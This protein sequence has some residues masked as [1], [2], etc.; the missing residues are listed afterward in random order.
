MTQIEIRGAW[1]AEVSDAAFGSACDGD[2]TALCE[3]LAIAAE[4]DGMLYAAAVLRS[5]DCQIVVNRKDLEGLLGGGRW[6]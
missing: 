5:G 4:K 2:E 3:E 6:P 1:W